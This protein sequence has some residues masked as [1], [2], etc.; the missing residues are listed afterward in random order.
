MPTLYDTQTGI[1][2]EEKEE[3]F[4]ATLLAVGRILREVCGG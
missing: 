3:Y 1:F 2:L 4:H